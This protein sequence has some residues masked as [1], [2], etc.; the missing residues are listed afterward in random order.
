MQ[1]VNNDMDDLFKKAA[2]EYPLQTGGADWNK[3]HKALQ[4]TEGSPGAEKREGRRRFTVLF[5]LFPMLVGGYFLLKN[6]GVT[7]VQTIADQTPVT[8]NS[9]KEN[10]A[11]RNI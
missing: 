7:P 11:N 4:Q 10:I 5:L 3:V 8:K 6:N 9:E 1:Q 2:E